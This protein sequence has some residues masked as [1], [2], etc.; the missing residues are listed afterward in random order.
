MPDIEEKDVTFAQV[1]QGLQLSAGH[2]VCVIVTDLRAPPPPAQPAK[3]DDGPGETPA[4]PQDS[5]DDAPPADS[6]KQPGGATPAAKPVTS[7]APQPGATPANPANP[8]KPSQPQPKPPA[9][10]QPPAAKKDDPKP[11]ADPQPPAAKKDD[12]VTPSM[13][14]ELGDSDFAF[15]KTFLLPKAVAAFKQVIDSCAKVK[16][17]RQILVVGHA[18]AKGK[19]KYNQAL[20]E[21]RARS[22][23]AFLK[24]DVG[25]WTDH[26]K[27]K[28]KASEKWGAAEDKLLTGKVGKGTRE[29]QVKKYMELA[30]A[31]LTDEVQVLG[32][33]EWHP[34]KEDKPKDAVNRRVDVFVFKGAEIKPSPDLCSGSGNKEDTERDPTVKHCEA[35]DAWKGKAEQLKIVYGNDAD[36]E[37]LESE[38][39]EALT[40]TWSAEWSC[41]HVMMA[42]FKGP[43]KPK[44]KSSYETVKAYFTLGVEL[45]VRREGKGPWALLEAKIAKSSLRISNDL[46][47]VNDANRDYALEEATEPELE[48]KGSFEKLLAPGRVLKDVKL[49][50]APPPEMYASKKL[51]EPDGRAAKLDES[52]MQFRYFNGKY[53]LEPGEESKAEPF[54]SVPHATVAFPDED[55]WPA[56]FRAFFEFKSDGSRNTIDADDTLTTPFPAQLEMQAVPLQESKREFESCDYLVSSKKLATKYWLRTTVYTQTVKLVKSEKS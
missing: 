53:W 51:E 47:K 7:D 6:P 23:V 39:P 11:P 40:Q 44:E 52:A 42:F 4:E 9:G 31:P 16:A 24:H 56:A 55:S 33:G 48:N 12:E 36:D 25:A 46:S 15:N 22:V 28:P 41:Q 2:G 37:V 13:V 3:G 34:K 5:G 49:T 19:P 35:Y 14:A 20:S 29:E 1:K 8:A 26:W 50:E 38:Q 43:K 27:T 17:P 32:C 45:K 21:E 54:K 18:D 30:G 10:P